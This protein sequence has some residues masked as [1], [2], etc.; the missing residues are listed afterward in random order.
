[1]LPALGL[2]VGGVV[3]LSDAGSAGIGAGAALL[4][5]GAVLFGTGA[6]LSGALR[7]IFA[8]ALYRFTTSGEAIGGFE[9]S[10]LEN[11]VRVKG[12]KT[13]PSTAVA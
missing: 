9:P 6:V 7:Q 8:V 11:A 3:I 12:R 4:A 13:G 2:M 5:L 10:A 1:M